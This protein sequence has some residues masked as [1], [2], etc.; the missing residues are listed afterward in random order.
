MAI[1]VNK[2]W[3]DRDYVHIL[4]DQAQELRECI[5]NYP[6]L[7][8]AS[9][10]DLQNYDTDRFGI[11]WRSLDEDLCFEYFTPLA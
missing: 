5:A 2:V 4:T 7:R 11:S 9:D 10:D 6:R 3:V 8:Q 1:N